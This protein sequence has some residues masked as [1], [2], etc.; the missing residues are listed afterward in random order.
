MP[1]AEINN[2]KIC[3]EIHGEGY[4]L[5]LVHGYDVKK[6]VWV[7]QIGVLSENF[8]VITVD[9]RSSGKSDRPEEPYTMDTLVEDLKGLMDFLKIDKA[10]L[11]GQSMGGWIIQNFVLKYPECA[12]KLILIATNHKGAGIHVL[13]ESL[14]KEIEIREKDPVE[15]FLGHARL[16]F[17]LKFRKQMEENLSKEFHGIWSPEDLIKE[18]TIDPKSPLDLENLANASASHNTLEKLDQIRNPTLLITGSHDRMSPKIVLDQMHEKLPNSTLK[19]I[20]KSGHKLFL[21]K[22]PEV[23]QIILEFLTD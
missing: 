5:I 21:S 12:N 8:K 1:F 10:N 4:P 13:K 16:M 22:A 23:N 20:D 17:H 11:M 6:E 3:Y 18:S 9:L 15:A 2:I 14:I 19:F 7:A